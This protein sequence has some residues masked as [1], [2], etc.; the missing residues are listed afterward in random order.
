M[1]FCGV[2]G[3]RLE[4]RLM[5]DPLQGRPTGN[6]GQVLAGRYLVRGFMGKGATSRVY[7]AE[8]LEGQRPVA[9]KILD[10]EYG[11]TRDAAT[12][13]LREARA[14][15]HVEHEN[16]VRILDV[17]R[18]DQDGA[19]YLVMEFLFGESLGARLRRDGALPPGDALV[20]AL[21]A[22]RGLHAAHLAGVVHRDVKVDNL[23]LV[24]EPGAAWAVKVLDFGLA[25][26]KELPSLTALGMAVGTVEYMAPEQA[27]AETTDARTDVYGLGVVLYRMLTGQL[28][29]AGSDVTLLAAQLF[30]APAA[31]SG[32]V[33]LD[34]G[35]ESVVLRAL[36]K[37]PD[38]RYPTMAA[39]AEDL[40]R[41][42][43]G[44]GGALFADS[45]LP[46]AVDE[47]EP[48]AS[49]ARSAMAFFRQRRV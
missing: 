20:V 3:T 32:I 12:R 30:D 49:F 5:V 42:G 15:A 25:R 38:N 29:F 47:F 4:E 44:R 41:I 10:E 17:S 9:V 39:L 43:G 6:R 11:R 1:S 18:R 21:Q 28:P 46:R 37:R 14:A 34:P 13:F 27:V 36:R 2:D 33:D 19:P 24:G 23:F 31:P 48:S 22:A 35:L 7:L 26:M 16:V 40:E 8:D 45:P